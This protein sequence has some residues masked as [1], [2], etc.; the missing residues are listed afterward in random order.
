MGE[1][2]RPTRG[3]PAHQRSIK[4]GP[5]RYDVDPEADNKPYVKSK[6]QFEFEAMRERHKLIASALL[7]GLCEG[8]LPNGPIDEPCPN[9]GT[10]RTKHG[11]VLVL[12][13]SGARCRACHKTWGRKH[14]LPLLAEEIVRYK[15]GA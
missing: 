1:R 13:Q 5:L 7:P 15:F 2:R 14:H 4:W 8:I 12:E 6:A 3:V 11:P 9:C 10:H